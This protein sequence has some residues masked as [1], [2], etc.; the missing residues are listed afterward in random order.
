VSAVAP[1]RR[2]WLWLQGLVCG[3]AFSIATG[4]VVLLAVLLAPGLITYVIEA[5]EKKPVS[6][7]MLLLGL[8]TCF[9][10]LRNLWESG[11]SINACIAVLSDPATAGL[12]W[13]A[14]GAGWLMEEAA[15]IIAK[16]SSDMA[17]RRRIA[18]LQ[19]ERADL[20]AEWGP[21]DPKPPQLPAARR[22]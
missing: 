4:P 21:L 12:S 2:S 3:A 18:Q 19:K 6:E 22:R 11:H 14:A 1:R 13:V 5:D 8:A 16:Q 10:P 9:F 15:Q 20:V 17:T 7:T